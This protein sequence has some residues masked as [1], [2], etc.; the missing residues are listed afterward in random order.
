MGIDD[1]KREAYNAYMVSVKKTGF[2]KYLLYAATNEDLDNLFKKINVK[3]KDVFTVLASSDHALSCYAS[4]AKSIDT[5]DIIYISLW[6][7]Y[8]R[9]WLIVYQNKFY[10]SY[11]FF[12]DG[13][14][15][16][17]ELICSITPSNED[18]ADAQIFWKEYMELH[19]YRSDYCLFN[20]NVCDQPTPFTGKIDLI[21]HFYDKP[22]S[23]KNLNIFKPVYT[24]K[25]YDLIFLSNILEHVHFDEDLVNVRNNIENLLKV[26]GEAICSSKIYDIDSP[27]HEKEIKVLTENKL[28]LENTYS[29]Y[30]PVVGRNMDLGYTYKKRF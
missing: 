5:F 11:H 16:L 3:D 13:D 14:R 25:K 21:K 19:N 1:V 9:K 2:D 4:G 20:S 26:G 22:I 7:A 12:K 23:F 15:E 27:Y 6:Y 18:E 28:S 24:N 30:E 29:Y 17:Y 8:L 10:P